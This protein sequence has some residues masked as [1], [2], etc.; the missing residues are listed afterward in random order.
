MSSPAAG[1][2]AVPDHGFQTTIN[3]PAGEPITVVRPFVRPGDLVAGVGSDRWRVRNVSFWADE[4]GT[5]QIIDV[6]IRESVARA[7][8]RWI[9]R[10]VYLLGGLLVGHCIGLVWVATGSV[11]GVVTAGLSSTAMV[12]IVAELTARHL[13]DR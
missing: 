2:I 1:W 5:R 4:H 11:Y 13:R 7:N 8:D 9:V 10:A 6:D 12:A 3:L